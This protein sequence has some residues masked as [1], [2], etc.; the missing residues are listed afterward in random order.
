[1]SSTQLWFFKQRVAWIAMSFCALLFAACLARASEA[2]TGVPETLQAVGKIPINNG[3]LLVSAIS[4]IGILALAFYVVRMKGQN[5]ERYAKLAITSAAREAAALEIQRETKEIL[6][7]LN[8][9]LVYCA[10]HSGR[11][12]AMEQAKH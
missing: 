12:A 6:K 9:N 2:L 5:E 4:V 10:N 7:E 3:L 11:T 1:M 8:T